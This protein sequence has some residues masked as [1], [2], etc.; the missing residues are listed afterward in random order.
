M[1]SQHGGWLPSMSDS[2][3]QVRRAYI[4][5]DL[6]SE[7]THHHF[8]ILLAP[9]TSSDWVWEEITEEHEYWE[10]RIFGGHLASQLPQ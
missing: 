9:Q 10:I 7:V 5:Y 8:H 4:F 6:A 1:F 2:E 3:V